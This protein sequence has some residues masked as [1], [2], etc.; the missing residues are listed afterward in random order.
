MSCLLD[1]TL[2]PSFVGHMGLIVDSLRPDDDTPSSS[3]A[4]D[5]SFPAACLLHD[6]AKEGKKCQDAIAASGGVAILLDLLPPEDAADAD[7]D[8]AIEAVSALCLLAVGSEESRCETF[9]LYGKNIPDSSEWA[10]VWRL[11]HPIRDGS[12]ADYFQHGKEG[13]LF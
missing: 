10:E 13:Q 9:V 4:P 2:I 12:A 8:H 5:V 1:E 11:P 6:F 7:L 3:T